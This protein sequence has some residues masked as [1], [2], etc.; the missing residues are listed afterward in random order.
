MQRTQHSL[1]TGPSGALRYALYSDSFFCAVLALGCMVAANALPALLGFGSPLI[2]A[3]IG[4]VV[5]VWAAWLSFI[6]HQQTIRLALARVPLYGNCVWVVGTIII[7]LS[8]WLPL[9]SAGM[10]ILG[11]LAICVAGFA[12]VLLLGIRQA[13]HT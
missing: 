12:L 8:G 9:T 6:A 5:V 11:L 2:F 1:A 4:A 3:S 7:F 10:W 13:E